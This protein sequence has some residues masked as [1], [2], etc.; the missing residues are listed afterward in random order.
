MKTGSD[1]KSPPL[2]C[3]DGSLDRPDV[4]VDPESRDLARV[5]PLEPEVSDVVAVEETVGTGTGR[6]D[7]A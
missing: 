6:E 5:R 4:L 1:H 7:V 3:G 2:L